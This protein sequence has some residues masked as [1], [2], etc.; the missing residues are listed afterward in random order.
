MRFWLLLSATIVYIV[1]VMGV[2]FLG[3]IP[4][5][6]TLDLFNLKSASL[7]EIYKQRLDF[8]GAWNRFHTIR[9]CASI[10]S[11]ILTILAC[12]KEDL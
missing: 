10:L 5:N 8:E 12:L 9:M 3:N 11:L 7:V 4:L 6:N 2:T 1:G